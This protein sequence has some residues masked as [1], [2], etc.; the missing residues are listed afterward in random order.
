MCFTA[1]SRFNQLGVIHNHLVHYLLMCRGY[2]DVRSSKSFHYDS[3]Y[4]QRFTRCFC[5]ANL[6][7]AFSLGVRGASGN[8]VSLARCDTH[9]PT[10][11]DIL[12]MSATM[13]SSNAWLID[14]DYNRIKPYIKPKSSMTPKAYSIACV[15]CS[16]STLT[17][18]P[19]FKSV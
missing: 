19:Y 16:A 12:S 6:W 5:F 11:K 10:L 7:H 9:P 2:I 4:G 1:S 8:C 15:F 3:V 18:L 17:P 13:N 14:V